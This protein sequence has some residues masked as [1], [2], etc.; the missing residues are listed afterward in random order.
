MANALRT[1]TLSAWG[2]RGRRLLGVALL[3][4]VLVS[5]PDNGTDVR[6]HNSTNATVRVREVAV[7]S[8]ADIVTTLPAGAD[9]QS[10]WRFNTGDRFTVRG[11]SMTG[12]VL[13][14]HAYSYEDLQQQNGTVN[15]IDGT[16]DCPS[17]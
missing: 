7:S 14:C 15:I 10:L 17:K 2:R 11:E 5:C 6:I 8:G 1:L 9:R 12:T 13:F 4:L 16:N 3:A